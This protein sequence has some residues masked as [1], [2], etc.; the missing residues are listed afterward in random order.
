[1]K[2]LMLFLDTLNGM[3]RKKLSWDPKILISHW[4]QI[5]LAKILGLTTYNISLFYQVIIY[6]TLIIAHVHQFWNTLQKELFYKQLYIISIRGMS[7]ELPE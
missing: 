1:M 6:G 5:S 2:L 4:L 7:L 3:L